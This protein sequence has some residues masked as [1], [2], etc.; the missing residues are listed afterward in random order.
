[1]LFATFGNEVNG[2]SARRKM[3]FW[4]M[5]KR[6]FGPKIAAFSVDMNGP[7]ACKSPPL[8]ATWTGFGPSGIWAF[9]GDLNRHS[10]YYSPP[11]ATTWTGVRPAGKWA[12]GPW[13]NGPSFRKLPPSALTWTDLRPIHRRFCRRRERS[14]GPQGT[15]A[16]GSCIATFKGNMHGPVNRCLR[17]RRKRVFGQRV[18]GPSAPD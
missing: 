15:W 9:G 7:S 12:S 14:F 8:T 4:P 16:F 6:A 17:H 13:L 11:S 1:M 2:S 5:I 3:G 18:H 10:A